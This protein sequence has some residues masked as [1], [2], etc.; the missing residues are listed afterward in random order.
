M[1]LERGRPDQESGSTAGESKMQVSKESRVVQVEVQETKSWL[2]VS[3]SIEPD[4]VIVI[5]AIDRN[6]VVTF[7][8]KTR[9]LGDAV[10]Q[11]IVIISN[12]GCESNQWPH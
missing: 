12:S 1:Q 2:I 8:Q 9:L 10:G 4:A 11:W 3:T 7:V 5:L 6:N